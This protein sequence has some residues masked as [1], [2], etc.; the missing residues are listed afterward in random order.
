MD[1]RPILYLF[2]TV[3]LASGFVVSLYIPN[4]NH[5]WATLRALC[6]IISCCC[7]LNTSCH[8]M[9]HFLEKKSEQWIEKQYYQSQKDK[10]N[11]DRTEEETEAAA[12]DEE[13]KRTLELQQQHRVRKLRS[14]YSKLLAIVHIVPWL[15]LLCAEFLLCCKQETLAIPGLITLFIFSFLFA[16]WG[17]K[18]LIPLIYLNGQWLLYYMDLETRVSVEPTTSPEVARTKPKG[19]VNVTQASEKEKEPLLAGASL[20]RRDSLVEDRRLKDSSRVVS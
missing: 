14:T 10:H 9:N 20:K 11:R 2:P 3:S 12:S 5:K 8:Q 18:L 4:I 16:N 17:D 19:E 13:Q 7:G 6:Y 15:V 1:F